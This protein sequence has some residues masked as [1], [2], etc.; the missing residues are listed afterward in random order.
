MFSLTFI[1]VMVGL[2]TANKFL[3]GLW[4]T[5]KVS[6]EV[7]FW[8]TKV[9]NTWTIFQRLQFLTPLTRHFPNF[10]TFIFHV[11]VTS[12]GNNYFVLCDSLG[13][14]LLRLCASVL[15][16]NFLINF[17]FFTTWL[18]VLWRFELK[19]SEGLEHQINC[20]PHRES[21]VELKVSDLDQ[22][23]ACSQIRSKNFYKH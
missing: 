3:V 14:N 8:S 12:P 13:L 2:W 5:N 9:V 21:I 7:D 20:S 11:F 22:S 18:E 1:K 15:K 19:L 23:G 17:L 16:Q 4:S 10:E 6:K